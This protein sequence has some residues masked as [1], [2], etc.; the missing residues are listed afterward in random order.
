MGLTMIASSLLQLEKTIK[1]SCHYYSYDVD[2]DYRRQSVID[3]YN[4]ITVTFALAGAQP[5][6]AA[7]RAGGAAH[8]QAVR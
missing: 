2:H 8:A 3:L 6:R 7:E 1:Y 5:Q 4:W